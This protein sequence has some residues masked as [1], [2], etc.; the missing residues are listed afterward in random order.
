M[1][2]HYGR[3]IKEVDR[4]TISSDYLYLPPNT[5]KY[6]MGFN[7]IN[8]VKDFFPGFIMV[9]VIIKRKV[10]L[11]MTVALMLFLMIFSSTAIYFL[12]NKTQPDNF[13]S[14]WAAM[15]WAVAALTTVGYGDVYPIWA[16]SHTCLLSLF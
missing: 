5:T 14:I 8:K 2:I 7:M 4:G 3:V 6:P 9:R 10:E 1:P 12:E 15:W 16:R 13:S 11:L